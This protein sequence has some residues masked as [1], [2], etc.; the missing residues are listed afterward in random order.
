MSHAIHFILNIPAH[1]ESL[2][3]FITMRLNTVFAEANKKPLI[4]RNST[5]APLF[6]LCFASGNPT[7]ARIAVNIAN[8]IINKKNHGH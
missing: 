6:L 5:G 3:D 2:S 8:H 1:S 7:G 4:L